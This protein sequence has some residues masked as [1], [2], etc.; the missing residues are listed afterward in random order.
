ME[1][2]P[3]LF[4]L[5]EKLEELKVLIRICKE[6]QAFNRFNSFVYAF[7]LVIEL[8]RQ[9]EGWIKVQKKG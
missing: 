7:D 1:R 9:N 6:V 4:E 5:R 3:L 8:S 2:L